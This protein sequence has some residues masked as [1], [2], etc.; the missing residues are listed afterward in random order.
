MGEDLKDLTRGAVSQAGEFF[1]TYLA[2]GI[3]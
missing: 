2:K 3:N 1:S